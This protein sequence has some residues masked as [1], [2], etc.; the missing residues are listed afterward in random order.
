MHPITRSAAAFVFA[1]FAFAFALVQ[2]PSPKAA[3]QTNNAI[4]IVSAGN[5]QTPIT[6]EGIAALFG[7][8]LAAQTIA[9]NTKPL[10]TTLGGV[11]VRVNNVA[12]PLF[13]VS[14]GQINFLVPTGTANGTAN[15]SVTASDGST[16]TGTVEIVNAAPALFTFNANGSGVAAALALRVKANNAQ[17]YEP[18]AQFDAAT[19]RWQPVPLNLGPAGERLFLVLYASGSRGV[20][21]TLRVLMGGVEVTPSFA[22]ASP[23]FFG[24]EQINVELTRSLIGRGRLNLSLIAPNTRASNTAEFDLAN[25]AA[26]LPGSPVITGITPAQA[27]AGETLTITGTG[28][29]STADGNTLI[30]GGV[31]TR[32]VESASA[33]RLVVR[34]PYGIESGKLAL[35]TALGDGTSANSVNALTT[36]SGIITDTQNNPLPN[37]VV[38]LGGKNAT[39]RNDGSYTIK[40]VIAGVAVLRVDASALPLTPKLPVTARSFGVL[41]NRDN[42][43]APIA[44]QPP[45]NNGTN[46]QTQINPPSLPSSLD[47]PTLLAALAPEALAASVTSG[48]LTFELPDNAVAT[49]PAGVTEPRIYLTRIENSRAPFALPRG[50]FSLAI[51]QLSPYGIKLNPGGKLIFPNADGLP[52][53]AQVALFRLNQTSTGTAL[54]TFVDAGVAT[55]SADGLR[56]ETAANAI[57]ETSIY[58]VAQLRPTTTVI[59]R[60][61]D[62]DNKPV[63][64]ALIACAGQLA[65][66]D[67]NGSFVILNVAVP[68]NG[69]LTVEASYIRPTGRTDRITRTG[70]TAQ[71]YSVTRLTPDLVLPSPVTQ[72]N[73]PP[74]LTAPATLTINESTT[75]DFALLV[76][77]PAPNQTV[78]VTV[79]GATFAS[80]ISNQGAF[81]LQL[82][83]GVNTAGSYTLTLRAADNQN[84]A[85]VTTR[86]VI[87]TVINAANRPPVAIAQTITTNEDTPKAITLTGS[88]AD[89][90]ALTYSIVAQPARGTLTGTGAN[91]TY[92]PAVNL[93]GADLFTF[94]VNDGKADSAPAT[95]SINVTPVNDAPVLTVPGT[96]T[97]TVGQ[98]L[99]FDLSATDVDQGQALTFN[100]SNLPNGATL[101]STG[102]TSRRF[103]WTP[104]A[105]QVGTVTVS[106]MVSDS[107]TPSLSDTKAITINVPAS[108][109]QT[110]GPFGGLIQDI[111]VNGTNLF[112][113]TEGRIFLSTNN[114]QSW[115]TVFTRRSGINSLVVSGNHLFAGSY[116]NVFL[117]TDNGQNWTSVNT[118][119][120]GPVFKAINTLVVSGSNLFAGTSKGVYLSTDNGQSWGPAIN[121]LGEKNIGSLTAIGNNLFAGT[122]DGLFLSTNNGQSWTIVNNGLPSFVTSLAANG[123]GLFA[124]TYNSGV[125]HSINNGQSWLAAN[126]GIIGNGIFSLAADGNK[127]FAGTT[128]GA[129]ISPNNGQSWTAINS[130]ITSQVVSALTVYGSNLIAGT[131]GAGVF[132]S[133]NSGQQWTP[134]NNGL[135][136]QEVL[137][138]VGNGADLFAGTTG[139]GVFH[140]SN[141]GQ[142]WVPVNNGLTNSSTISSLIVNGNNLFAGTFGAGVFLS[143]NKGQN[144]T[145]VNNG[146]ASQ[147]VTSL[148]A[149]GSNLFAGT[150]GNGGVYFSADNGQHWTAVNNG[151]TTLNVRSLVVNGSNLFAGTDGG[152]VFRSTNNG[153]SW[154][155]VNNGIVDNYVLC[156]A[157]SGSNLFA[158][159]N[160]AGVFRSTNNGQSWTP[161]NNGLPNS[162]IYTLAVSGNNLFVGAHESVFLSTNNGESWSDISSG[163]PQL[164]AR[165]LVVNGNNVFAGTGGGSVFVRPLP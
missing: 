6:P 157:A 25:V 83:P 4:A 158:G 105:N 35:R 1:L 33:T 67:G 56:I 17:S 63:R 49:L 54:G 19:N 165:S 160:G 139:G 154:T 121:G 15:I 18:I 44:L 112:V 151:L 32:T 164:L 98:A 94:K 87:V 89:G 29:S 111:A 159:T 11:T 118:G 27:V 126:N 99:N 97:A 30:I 136:G 91:L 38:S 82:A 140:S 163:L 148:V 59:G 51:A 103:S 10:P 14:A 88:D 21:N 146:L 74:S 37:V 73:R 147:T 137:S 50:L 102:A 161:V 57:T 150:N 129:Y 100:S 62:S 71:A 119:L 20:A 153:Q 68:T 81:A 70:I 101:T 28:F 128:T 77:D 142:S 47:D 65:L 40:D 96:Q 132:F 46:V 43:Q 106:F 5:Y 141:Y 90:D 39:T 127:V 16:R 9:A 134:I 86:A 122:G 149:N 117:S 61:V 12:A 2:W 104:T 69:Q 85:G 41:A 72:P 79:S 60:V 75:R 52:A 115:K 143:T 93:N 113:A 42:L 95:V 24:V 22:G 156:M 152:G 109:T 120:I 155:L 55:V 116:T 45:S 84:P 36:V 108:W 23:D 144:W 145:P 162:T 58:F 78:T 135:T 131:D 13:F 124:G 53:N 48:G 130:G 110:N 64:F 26:D 34:V 133:A 7:Q 107:G 76:S 138:L 8:G 125:F 3:L 92:T 31:E 80:I 123:S 66:T 114:G